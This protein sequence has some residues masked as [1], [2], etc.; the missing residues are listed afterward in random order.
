VLGTNWLVRG[1]RTERVQ[2]PHF[3]RE[4]EPVR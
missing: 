1:R 2:E 4:E 3:A